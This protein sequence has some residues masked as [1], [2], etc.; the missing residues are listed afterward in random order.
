MRR[1]TTP[2]IPQQSL[3]HYSSF[4]AAESRPRLFFLRILVYLRIEAGKLIFGVAPPLSPASFNPLLHNQSL[5][6]IF[7]RSFLRYSPNRQW[8]RQ[9]N[10]FLRNYIADIA[11][12]LTAN[13][14]IKEARQVAYAA[15]FSRHYSGV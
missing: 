1:C 2:W 10:G 15:A 11:V 12:Y 7:P 9:R 6:R 8:L 14:A 13:N 4:P 5:P 3:H